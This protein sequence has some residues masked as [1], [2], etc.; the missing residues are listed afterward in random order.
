MLTIFITSSLTGEKMVKIAAFPMFHRS[1]LTHFDK[2]EAMSALNGEV[3]ASTCYLCL[4]GQVIS[5]I[6]AS[7]NSLICSISSS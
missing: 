2:F 7:L 6:N 5:V 3:T 4:P 1:N